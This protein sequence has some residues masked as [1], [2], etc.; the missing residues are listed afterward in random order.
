MSNKDNDCGVTN[1]RAVRRPWEITHYFKSKIK[2]H[3][4]IKNN[5]IINVPNKHHLPIQNQ[6]HTN[7]HK[8]QQIKLSQCGISTPKQKE[9]GNFWGDSNTSKNPCALR[10]V[11]HNIQ[12]LLLSKNQEKNKSI[13]R[14]LQ[15]M[16]GAEVHL[17]Q[18]IGINWSNID[19]SNN[20]K[21]RTKRIKG[22]F[23]HSTG[24]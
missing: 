13:M 19:S 1:R 7:L 15:G 20:W 9:I 21:S 5:C 22:F 12:R 11:S 18:E 4:T 23:E 16:D 14:S 24:L 10:V 2:S 8:S 6:A 17:Y 3:R